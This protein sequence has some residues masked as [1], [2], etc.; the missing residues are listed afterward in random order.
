MDDSQSADRLVLAIVENAH[1]STIQAALVDKR[2]RVT[3][4]NTAGGFLKKGNATLLV[5]VTTEQVEQVIE[6]IKKHTNKPKDGQSDVPD[7][8]T[9]LFVIPVARFARI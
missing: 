8:G 4:L 3:R 6:I 7:V 5:G 9:M 1:A 2:F